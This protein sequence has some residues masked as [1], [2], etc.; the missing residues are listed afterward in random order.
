MPNTPNRGGDQSTPQ[1]Q[2]KRQQLNDKSLQQEG[3]ETGEDE[4]VPDDDTQ[5]NRNPG[6]FANDR[7]K[8]SE[9]GRKGGKR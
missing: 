4:D 5:V 9:A 7:D 6:N 3:G 8:A 1:Q 2:R